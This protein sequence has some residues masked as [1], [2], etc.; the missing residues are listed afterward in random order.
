M[1]YFLIFFYKKN[2]FYNKNDLITEL[3]TIKKMTTATT[4]ATITDL[5]NTPYDTILTTYNVRTNPDH[6]NLFLVVDFNGLIIEK[7]DTLH[8]IVCRNQNVFEEFP[9]SSLDVDAELEYCEDGTVI[10]VYNYLD[11]W[12][13][14]TTKKMDASKAFWGGSKSFGEMFMESC[15]IDWDSLDTNYTYNYIL[16]HVENRIVV[17]HHVNSVMFVSKINNMSGE[18]DKT[19]SEIE[20]FK[21]ISNTSFEEYFIGSKRGVIYKNYKYDFSNY[22]LVKSVR[23]NVPH[24]QMRYLQLLNDPS[25]LFILENT[26]PECHFTFA[27]V[28]H[29]LLNLYK[30]VHS[31]YIESHVKHLMQVYPAHPMYRTLKQLHSQYKSDNTVITL[32]IVRNKVNN[33]NP[34]VIAKLM[35]WNTFVKGANLIGEASS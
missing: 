7:G 13:V 4:I 1:E 25:S 14:A 12:H 19:S 20:T 3:T 32:D 31:M 24:M 9:A 23:G 34:Y 5:L 2:D 30:Q 16:K 22:T 18:V 33:L 35:H 10:R 15:K 28:K 26:Y 21:Y 8:R 29:C 17:N 11:S 27:M 6:P